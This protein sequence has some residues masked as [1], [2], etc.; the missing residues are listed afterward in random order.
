MATYFNLVISRGRSIGRW[1]LALLGS[2]KTEVRIRGAFEKAEWQ[3]LTTALWTRLAALIAIQLWL[4]FSVPKVYTIFY[5]GWILVFLLMG[6]VQLLLMHRR[7][8]DRRL[9]YLFAVLDGILIAVVL[10]MPNP[11]LTEA[12]PPGLILRYANIVFIFVLLAGAAF[13]YNPGLVLC[14]GISSMVVWRI[15]VWMLA[16]RSTALT[17]ADPTWISA[18]S[19]AAT[20]ALF[21]DPEFIH[22]NMQNKKVFVVILVT[23]LLAAVVWRARRLVMNQVAIERARTNLARYFSPNLVDELAGQDEPLGAVRRQ[24]VAVLFADIQGFTRLSENLAPEAVVELLRSFHERM[25]TAVF[26]HDGTLDKYMGDGLMA[27]FGTPTPGE[28]DATNALLAA[29]RMLTELDELNAKRQADGKPAIKL[30]IGIHYGPVVQGDIGGGRRLEFTVLGD[31]VNVA[32]RLEAMTRDLGTPLA[33]SGDMVDQLKAETDT[34]DLTG[35]IKTEPQPIRGREARLN[36][37]SLAV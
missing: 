5:H 23:I 4:L 22:L 18:D 21:L 36:I 1:G 33:I 14:T 16:S 35:L 15:G 34:P 7:I 19:N 37:W 30:S 10:L 25:E 32:S 31:T 2:D 20:M 27:T 6:T 12:Y 28:Q 24:S 29:R 17:S 26:V 8:G 3:G 11:L 9:A 13:S